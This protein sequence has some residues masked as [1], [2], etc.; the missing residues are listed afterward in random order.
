MKNVIVF[1]LVL[2]LITLLCVTLI[3]I[4]QHDI[5]YPNNYD[6]INASK[7]Y[8][9]NLN[10]SDIVVS[11]TTMPKRLKQETLKCTIN[12]FLNQTV[13]A[14]EI[15]I[16]IPSILKKSG[17]TYEIPQWL[18]ETPITIVRCDDEGPATKYLPTIRHFQNSQQKIFICDDDQIYTKH[19][20]ETYQKL[21]KQYPNFAIGAEG[22]KL[23]NHTF[24]ERTMISNGTIRIFP[25]L[26][27]SSFVNVLYGSGG[28]CIK[29]NM[30]DISFLENFQQLPKEAFFVDD[31]VMSGGMS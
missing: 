9:S 4:I 7:F 13:R 3:V 28:Y 16:N 31:I 30:V 26:K 2:I 6:H 5:D 20:I 23:K 10:I 25:R 22:A 29:A 1:F 12:S 27:D 15:R 14:Q 17:E 18:T 11:F 24:D 8:N 21:T 19:T